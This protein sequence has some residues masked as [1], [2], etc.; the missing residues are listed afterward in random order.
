MDNECSQILLQILRSIEHFFKEWGGKSNPCA[1]CPHRQKPADEQWM[2]RHQVMAYLGISRSNYYE[3]KSEG[4]LVPV[5]V[6]S[7][8]L[9]RKS[10][11]IAALE[12]SIRKGKI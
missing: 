2:D 9:Y 4:T 1:H 10:D 6:G 5:K 8:D 11:L 3:R 7:K 12:Q